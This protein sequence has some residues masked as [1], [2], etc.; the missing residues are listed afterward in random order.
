VARFIPAE[1]AQSTLQP[2]AD[3]K[4]PE[5][6][7]SDGGEKTVQEK[8]SSSLSPWALAGIVATSLLVSLAI[9][10]L[11]DT[12]P[13]DNIEGEK[14]AWRQIEANYFSDPAGG[15]LKPYNRML[16]E[17][18]RA[19]QSQDRK[20]Q[21]E[22]LGKVRDLLRGERGVNEKGLTGSRDRD[23]TLERH[24]TVLLNGL[25]QE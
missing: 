20:S 11:G 10:L 17:A 6:H 18:K 4:L 25:R 1:A 15:E 23:K 13:P 5:L 2:T 16:R 14:A 24:V 3:G 12:A 19:Q 21:R 9:L 22:L 7:L 8:K